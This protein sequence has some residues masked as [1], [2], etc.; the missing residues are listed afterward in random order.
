LILNILKIKVKYFAFKKHPGC[1]DFLYTC[2]IGITEYLLI[3]CKDTNCHPHL[4]SR[5]SV[6]ET[7]GEKPGGSRAVPT[8]NAL[9]PPGFSPGVSKTELRRGLNA[10]ENLC[11]CKGLINIQLFL[12]HKCE[13]SV[14]PGC[15]FLF[16]LTLYSSEY[17]IFFV[18]PIYFLYYNFFILEHMIYLQQSRNYKF[19]MSI[20]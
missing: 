19:T 3:L 17:L 12:F 4:T 13:K 6:F 9:D 15:L 10:G 2:R 5:N 1:T 14:Q 8:W 7:P 18:E 11:L 16:F 20:L